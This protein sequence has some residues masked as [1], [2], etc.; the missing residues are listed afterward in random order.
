MFKKLKNR[1]DEGHV[2]C[3]T[4]MLCVSEKKNEKNVSSSSVCSSGEL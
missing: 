1:N 4:A 2:S 3:T